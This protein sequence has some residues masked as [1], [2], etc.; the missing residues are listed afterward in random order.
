MTVRSF[1]SETVGVQLG[2]EPFEVEQFEVEPFGVEQFEVVPSIAAERSFE[3]AW[4]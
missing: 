1:S 3:G 4:P 2:V